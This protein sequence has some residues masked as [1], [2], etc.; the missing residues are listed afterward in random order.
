MSNLTKIILF[1]IPLLLFVQVGLYAQKSSNQGAMLAASRCD[2]STA[3]R[4]FGKDKVDSS[5]YQY[6]GEMLSIAI[7]VNCTELFDFLLSKQADV[8]FKSR[9]TGDAPLH[10]A[11]LVGNID[12]AK[13]LITAGAD[14]NT[15]NDAG[16]TAL[17]QAVV[18]RKIEVVKYLI[19]AGADTKITDEKRNSLLMDS[20]NN[21]ELT[22]LFLENGLDVNAQNESG[23]TALTY[24]SCSSDTDVL[25]VLI[26]SGADANLKD[27]D[28]KTPLMW[29]AISG[30]VDSVKT[31]L[32][33]GIDVNAEDSNGKS[34]LVYAK[35][36]EENSALIIELLKNA[37]AFDKQ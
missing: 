14:V 36:S 20:V 32:P 12:L 15:Q 27:K 5:L 16:W 9:N 6:K 21:A 1:L 30:N 18:T 28:G 7:E 25:K 17:K 26:A 33:L 3:K 35:E 2:V 34:A 23:W 31:L 11:A 19:A 10:T 29:A 8:N 24:A 37:G 13:R 22:K 4:R